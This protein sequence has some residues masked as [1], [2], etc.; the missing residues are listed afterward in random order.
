MVVVLSRSVRPSRR[1]SRRRRLS[2]VRPSTFAHRRRP[3][4]VRPSAPSSS[5]VNNRRILRPNETIHSDVHMVPY[6]NKFGNNARIFGG[7]HGIADALEAVTTNQGND[8]PHVHAAMPIVAPYQN[9]TL[10]YIRESLEKDQNQF[11]HIKRF[12]TH[13]CRED[14]SDDKR[15][16]ERL[17]ALERAKPANRA[18]SPH[19]R[20]SQL[21]V[22]YRPQ[23][24]PEPNCSLWE[25]MC[26]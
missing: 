20:L 2:S 14:Q 21:L 7:P 19:M 12:I 1:P 8:T 24:A 9:K 6:Q 10:T 26:H 11:D 23:V 15:H 3:S 13:L 17:A 16:Q 22:I 25:Q 18:G 5:H 4:A